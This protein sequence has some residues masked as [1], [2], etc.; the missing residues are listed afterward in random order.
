MRKQSRILALGVL[1]LSMFA[2]SCDDNDSTPKGDINDPDQAQGS[3]SFGITDAPIDQA[4]VSAA[5]ITVTEIKVDGQTFSGFQGPQTFNLL[6]LQNGNSLDLGQG[7]VA[8]GS[9]SSLELVIDAESD[10]TGS[11]PGCYILKTDGTKEKLELASG[12]ATSITMAPSDFKVEENANTEIIMDFDLRK[13]VKSSGDDYSF[14]TNNELNAAVR[15]ENK[16]M[17]GAIK[18]QIDNAAAASGKVVVYVYEKGTFDASTETSG[19]GSSDVMYANAVSSAKVNA[20]GTFNLSFLSEGNYEIQC[21]MPE[22]ND[23][24]LG[25]S[26]LL[27]LESNADLSNVG[28]NAG[29]ETNLN[30]SLKLEGLLGAK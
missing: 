16:A 1:A 19:Q 11:G 2:F 4:D 5:F 27:E 21:D 29:A 12:T 22:E 18:G 25:L 26:T 7:N 3:L 9:Y 6:E 23:S 24:G 8:A 15:A 14:V 17:T 30:L 20:D 10:A 13:S 28:V